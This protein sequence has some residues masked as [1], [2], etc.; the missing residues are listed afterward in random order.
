MVQPKHEIEFLDN[1]TVFRTIQ[2]WVLKVCIRA[3]FGSKMVGNAR[4]FV[5]NYFLEQ[6]L[7]L[8]SGLL[9]G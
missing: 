1:G 9:N 2:G 5:I 8:V 6:F 3:G 4:I 7:G